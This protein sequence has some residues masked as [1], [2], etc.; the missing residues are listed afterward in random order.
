[1][2]LSRRTVL[3][4][5]GAAGAGV[6]LAAC[7]EQPSTS[8]SP[9]GTDGGLSGEITVLTP[10]FTG[11]TERRAAYDAVVASFQDLHPDVR[12]VTDHTDFSKLNEKLTASVASGTT[13]D[14]I[15]TGVGWIEHFADRGIFAA[16]DRGVVEGVD[17]V[18]R[19]L[20]PCTFQNELYALPL[21]LDTRAVI[22]NRAMWEE[23]GLNETPT[24]FD[25]FREAAKALTA[26]SGSSKRWGMILNGIGSPSHILAMP[27]GANG[28]RMF[29]EDGR[30][31]LYNSPET[32][33]AMQFLV[34]L[35]EDGSA[36]WDLKPAEGSP[37]PFVTG[38]VGMSLFGDQHWKPWSEANP[39]LLSEEG[40]LVFRMQNA[41]ESSFMGGTLVSRSATSQNSEAADAF[42]RHLCCGPQEVQTITEALSAVPPLQEVL[43]ASQPLQENRFVSFGVEGLEF[44]TSEGGTPNYLEIRAAV[45]PL[46]EEAFIGS[47]DVETALNEANEI[48]QTMIDRDA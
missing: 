47:K 33:E 48:A 24:T 6:M 3:A 7:G 42:I 34:G 45:V 29:S 32:V 11:A 10:I 40:S 30:T 44:A 17:Y 39:E 41:R 28:G 22:V 19:I 8:P 26:G 31:A 35:I 15:M 23:A 43:D 46:L 20:E 37:H 5:F 14:V 13:Q 12:V 27:M 25:E 2:S 21:I 1:M 16:L 9:G 18:D 38:A 4:S 36:T